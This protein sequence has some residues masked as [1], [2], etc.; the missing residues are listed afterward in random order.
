M[1]MSIGGA[2][3]GLVM[4]RECGALCGK[5]MKRIGKAKQSSAMT[6]IVMAQQ[7]N[8]MSSKGNDMHCE[9]FARSGIVALG[10]RNDQ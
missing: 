2:M 5:A 7:S 1:V 6:C 9:G 4:C 8:A 3:T 10:G